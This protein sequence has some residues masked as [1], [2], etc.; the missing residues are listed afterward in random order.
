MGGKQIKRNSIQTHHS[1]TDLTSLYLIAQN[2]FLE[3][4]QITTSH[5]GILY[6]VQERLHANKDYIVSNLITKHRLRQ[7]R[8]NWVTTYLS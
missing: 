6:D 3:V 7:F 4:G 5:Q 8:S 1:F 2:M